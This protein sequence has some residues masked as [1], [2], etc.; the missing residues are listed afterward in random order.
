MMSKLPAVLVMPAV[1]S[2]AL[3]FTSKS[4]HPSP[5]I[6]NDLHVRLNVLMPKHKN[7]QECPCTCPHPR[8]K[9]DLQTLCT[10]SHRSQDGVR[11]SAGSSCAGHKLRGQGGSLGRHAS[12]PMRIPLMPAT[13]T[14]AEV[15]TCQKK[16]Y[17]CGVLASYS[18]SCALRKKR[19]ET[20][21]PLQINLGGHRDPASTWPSSNNNLH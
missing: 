19:I 11:L 4:K 1:D 21:P 6:L 20:S 17:I 16:A 3:E 10:N 9:P 14:F 15:S 8:W 12:K 5:M 7:K 13:N 2:A 18:T